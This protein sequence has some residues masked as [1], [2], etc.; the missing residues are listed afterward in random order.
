MGATG[1]TVDLDGVFRASLRFQ[2]TKDFVFNI[3]S[4]A[5]NDLSQSAGMAGND[6]AGQAFAASYQATAQAIMQAVDK[7]GQGMSAVAQRLLTMAWN[8]LKNE[9]SIAGALL[10][11]EPDSTAGLAQP[12]AGECEP[13]NA[14]QSLPQVLG[15]SEQSSIP[16]IGRYWPQGDP[17]KLR[18]AGAIWMKAAS[19]IDQAQVNARNEAAPVLRMSKGDAIAGFSSYLSQIVAAQPSG[20]TTVNSSL[21]LLE[22]ASAGCRLLAQA[23]TGY[24]DAITKQRNLLRNL[25]IAAGVI[26]AAGV[27]L[28]IFTAGM[29]DEGAAAADAALAAEAA[30]AAQAYVAAEA[31][32]AASAAV[33][34]A[35]VIIL[36][37]VRALQVGVKA[38]AAATTIAAV[39]ITSAAAAPTLPPPPAPR[40]GFGPIPPDNP[41]AFPLYDP[42]R[43]AAAAAWAHSLPMRP[44]N[45]GIEE[46]R[47]YQRRIAGPY[48]YEVS[49]TNGDS[50]NADGFRPADGAYIEAKNVRSNNKDCMPRS[51]AGLQQTDG[52]INWIGPQDEQMLADYKG[53]LENPSNQGQFLEIDTNNSLA[54]PYWRIK[55][56][57]AEVPRFA[58]RYAP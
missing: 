50:I 33:T 34:E 23:C 53:V 8:Y 31:A 38:V 7:G 35:E 39:T 11:K 41:P 57:Q 10:G 24:A 45:Y 30:T 26:T 29:S 58:V 56:A 22:N 1:F 9:D 48:E 20:G 28:T 36:A 46:D 44:A 47:E 49:A 6:A 25:A 37:E 17:A 51:L 3:E 52:A 15:Q 14:Y 43:A 18:A 55:A 40:G 32:S 4:G 12:Q 19:L 16:V 27:V 5:V 21:P 42:A 2:D 13:V 54:L